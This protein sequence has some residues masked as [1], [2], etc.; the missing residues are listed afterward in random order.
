MHIKDVNFLYYLF[1]APITTI[2]KIYYHIRVVGRENL[3]FDKPTLVIANHSNS[4]VDPTAI[5]ASI[6][7]NIYFLPRG[8]VFNSA[9]KRWVFWQFRM[10]PIYRK[11]E[12]CPLMVKLY[13]C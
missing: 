10:I 9:F 3:K 7:T 8:D 5:A 1:R 11:E 13:I 2:I 12:G 6:L 4:V